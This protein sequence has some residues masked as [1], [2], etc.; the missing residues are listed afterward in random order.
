MSYV[1]SIY[2]YQ[3]A[4]IHT[5]TSKSRSKKVANLIIHSRSETLMLSQTRII[6]PNG[7]IPYMRVDWDRAGLVKGEER[8]TVSNLYTHT[9]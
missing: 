1:D 7:Y 8:Y 4:Y 2:V 3:Y 9:L 5:R 6:V